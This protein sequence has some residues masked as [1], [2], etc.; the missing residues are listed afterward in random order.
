[1][2]D[3]IVIFGIVSLALLAAVSLVLA[4]IGFL[5]RPDGIASGYNEPDKS[6]EGWLSAQSVR[7]SRVPTP[8]LS[9]NYIDRPLPVHHTTQSSRQ[10]YNPV[11]LE[12]I[13]HPRARSPGNKPGPCSALGVVK[14]EGVTQL[15]LQPGYFREE[16]ME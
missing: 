1:M 11:L 10:N 4:V 3:G 12:I 14:R 5:K 6:K 13:K 9:T 7:S 15:T 2:L 16:E 8:T